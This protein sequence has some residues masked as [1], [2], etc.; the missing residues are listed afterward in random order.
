MRARGLS[1]TYSWDGAGR[2]TTKELPNGISAAY[3]WDAADRLTALTYRRSDASVV[4]QLSYAYD[5]A[6]QR[7]E[8]TRASGAS[9]PETPFVASYDADRRAVS[10]G[11]AVGRFQ[12]V[13]VARRER[14]G[15]G[16]S[17]SNGCNV[18]FCVTA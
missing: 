15:P 3:T 13:R 5:A 10:P 14:D 7:I 2:L 6:G 18:I 11:G 16:V 1:T 12:K 17:A 4:E 9:V 8:K